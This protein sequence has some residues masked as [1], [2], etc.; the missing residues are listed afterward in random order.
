LNAKMAAILKSSFL[1]PVLAV[2]TMAF[3]SRAGLYDDPP[4]KEMVKM[5]EATKETFKCLE[6]LSKGLEGLLSRLVTTPSCRKYYEVQD[7]AIGI[8]QKFVDDKISELKKMA[9]EGNGFAEDGG[10]H[11]TTD[12]LLL[13]LS[14]L[15]LTEYL[16]SRI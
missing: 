10:K 12:F 7:I 4:N 14:D 5:I 16:H 8:S 11:F 2:G 9:E 3:A 6:K 13:N 15:N 1:V